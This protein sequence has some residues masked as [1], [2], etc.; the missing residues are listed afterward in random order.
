MKNRK[1]RVALLITACVLVTI[2]LSVGIP[3]I[4]TIKTDDT[5]FYTV[6]ASGE[7]TSGPEYT[8][9]TTAAA[10]SDLETQIVLE[11]EPV[12]E[13]GSE[14]APSES[15]VGK[16]TIL[17]VGQSS[18]CIILSADDTAVFDAAD[19]EHAQ[20]PVRVLKDLGVTKISVLL[21]SHWDADHV[22]AALGI[23]KNF[24][25]EQFLYADYEADTRT[26]QSVRS[27][28]EENNPPGGPPEVGDQ[29]R[30]GDLVL[31]ITGPLHYS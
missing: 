31:T 21:C 7:E 1:V 11:E 3:W 24:S 2:I 27:Y 12:E 6:L 26:Y 8:W 19:P 5:L 9:G 30:I 23:L 29:F 17:D 25:V 10:S 13:Y 20:I 22:G 4:F 28:I 15:Y 18:C 14:E 16:I